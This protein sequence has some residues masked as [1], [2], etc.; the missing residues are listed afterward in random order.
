MR[1][2]FLGLRQA[3]GRKDSQFRAKGAENSRYG[4][5][6]IVTVIIAAE[7]R[8][9]VRNAGEKSDAA[10]FARMANVRSDENSPMRTTNSDGW[11]KS[12]FGTAETTS[13]SAPHRMVIFI[14]AARSNGFSCSQ[15]NVAD[16]PTIQSPCGVQCSSL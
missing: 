1:Q 14:C 8:S 3:Q 7:S 10:L 5:A 11:A 13:S 9:A 6:V 15:V 4:L 2:G 16:T 12:G